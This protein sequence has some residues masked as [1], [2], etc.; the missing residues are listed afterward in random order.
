MLF[1]SVLVFNLK[2]FLV[3]TRSTSSIALDNVYTRSSMYVFINSFTT[4]ISYVAETEKQVI[5]TFE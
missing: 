1:N 5:M 2:M 4:S 3:I